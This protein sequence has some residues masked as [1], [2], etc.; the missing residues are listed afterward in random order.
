MI[1]IPLRSLPLVDALK[2]DDAMLRTI[3]QL[4]N[5]VLHPVRNTRCYP[6]ES[7][8]FL[9]DYH[10]DPGARP[11]LLRAGGCAGILTFEQKFGDYDPEAEQTDKG[12][13]GDNGFHLFYSHELFYAGILRP[14]CF[15]EISWK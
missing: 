3:Y 5:F 9:D 7:F 10:S 6:S 8:S 14:T 1:S 2:F 12:G 15:V 4:V 11:V 13:A